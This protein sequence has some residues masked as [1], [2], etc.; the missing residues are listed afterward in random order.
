MSKHDK[1]NFQ[2]P[3]QYDINVNTKIRNASFTENKIGNSG[4]SLQVSTNK[5]DLFQFFC[6]PYYLHKE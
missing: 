2:P 4:K 3:S 1:Q 6:L 5:L